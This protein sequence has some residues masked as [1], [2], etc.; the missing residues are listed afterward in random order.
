MKRHSASDGK[1]IAA[2][3]PAHG[4]DSGPPIA[5]RPVAVA[6]SG[7]GARY[8]AL[9]L[10]AATILFVAFVR[11]RLAEVPFERDEGE[12][13]YAGQLILHGVPPYQQAFNMKF[14]GTYYAYSLIMAVFGQTTGAV[15]LGLLLV[16][17]ASVLLVFAIGRRLYGR[18][19]GA[20][21]AASFA[22]L[23]LDRWIMGVFAHATHFVL[24]PA[25]GGLYL[26]LRGPTTRRALWLFAAGVLLGIAVLV[27]Q[28][29]VA[30]IPLGAGVV[31]WGANGAAGRGTQ[32]VLI[33]L[34][35]LAAGTLL[36]FALMLAV[37]Q[38]QGVLANFWF[39]T[40]QYAREYVSQ[41]SFRDFVPNL[42]S[43]LLRVTRATALLWLVGGL[44]L[45]ALWAGRW[46][47]ADKVFLTALLVA[48][49]VAV[50]P[51]LYFREHYFILMLPAV[52]LL[53]GVAFVSLGRVLERAVAA[54]VARG[55]AATAFVAVIALLVAGQ[56][57]FLFEMSPRELSRARYGRNPF[58]ESVEVARYIREHTTPADRIAV[59]GSEPQ[60]Y[61]Y[62]D[63]RSATGYLYMYPLMEPQPFATRMQD[64]MIQQI[65][66][67]RP[68]YLILVQITASWLPR[69]ASQKRLVE[70]AN[71]YTSRL[72]D[73]VGIADIISADRTRYV[74]DGQVAGYQPESKNLVFVFRR[75][76]E[77][78]L[79][80][81]SQTRTSHEAP[82]P[83]VRPRLT[84]HPGRRT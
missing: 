34:G 63:R 71:L 3:A 30:F 37:L 5:R 13:A 48:S 10:V 23:S 62:S 35:L 79:P 59:L 26:L 43:G 66:T 31:V 58:I 20:T 78:P 51:G 32:R 4:A 27:K 56:R 40:F 22:L 14:P 60:I 52:A 70:W 25:L 69:N 65:E 68:T 54:P 82:A 38:H 18:F 1:A 64:E 49:F 15:R 44:G 12:Y 6:G 74:W 29:A 24:L 83:F 67:A 72:Y 76:G 2:S 77:V 47:A 80:A 16:N 28:H 61:F 53:D 57:D 7:G 81:S 9:A 8:A 45:I 84:T 33:E 46:R 55:L 19:A 42:A 73:L 11:L 75:K 39:W 21:A 17:A 36:P 41:L 50:C